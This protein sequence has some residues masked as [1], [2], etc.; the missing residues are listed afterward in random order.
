MSLQMMRI[1]GSDQTVPR[2]EHE[3][4]MTGNLGYVCL[5][6]LA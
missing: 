3:P 6:L 1:G 2:H 5:R 4:N